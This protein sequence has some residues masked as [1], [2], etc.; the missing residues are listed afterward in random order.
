MNN[1]TKESKLDDMIFRASVALCKLID[2]CEDC[3]FCDYCDF[4]SRNHLS[5][6]YMSFVEWLNE[7]TNENED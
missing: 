1:N 3:P 5:P 2:K 7:E 4:L 6:Y